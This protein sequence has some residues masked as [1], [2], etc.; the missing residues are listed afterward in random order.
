MILKW[1]GVLGR[2]DL[3][4]AW[5]W[6]V[7]LLV[8]I[9]N[10]DPPIEKFRR[11]LLPEQAIFD[12]VITRYKPIH[13][14]SSF[15]ALPSFYSREFIDGTLHFFSIPEGYSSLRN[16]KEKF[17]HPNYWLRLFDSRLELPIMHGL[18]VGRH[19]EETLITKTCWKNPASSVSQSLSSSDQFVPILRRYQRA[20]KQFLFAR[21]FSAIEN[22]ITPVGGWV[23]RTS[24]LLFVICTG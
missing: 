21:L 12:V 2:S 7:K 14:E 11:I 4:L 15:F 22:S 20:S 13:T 6:P 10:R 8:N 1:L 17:D 19:R 16:S 18:A 24:D 23:E 3:Y 9:S 5:Y